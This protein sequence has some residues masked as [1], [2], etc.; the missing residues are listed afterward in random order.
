MVVLEEALQQ[1][2]DKEEAQQNEINAT[3]THRE[4]LLEDLQ[5]TQYLLDSANTKNAEMI[6]RLQDAGKS[7][8]AEVEET[9]ELIES[10]AI[11]LEAL[12]ATQPRSA[13]SRAK[14][15][16][17]NVRDDPKESWKEQ[18]RSYNKTPERTRTRPKEAGR[19]SATKLKREDSESGP[20]KSSV[21]QLENDFRTK[22]N[23]ITI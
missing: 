12:G 11:E 15:S 5:K 22:V 20:D 8:L 19:S 21:S 10:M 1:A 7:R 14:P 16:P 17:V 13:R 3:N 9:R 18:L 2:R 23:A 6:R 4:Q